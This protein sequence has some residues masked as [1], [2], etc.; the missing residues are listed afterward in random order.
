MAYIE[1]DNIQKGFADGSG[2]IRKVL[3]CL[4]LKVEQGDFVAVTGVS[5]TGKTTL[6]NILGTLLQPDGGTYQLGG[7]CINDMDERRLLQ[8]RN[9][10]IGFMFQ[11]YRLLP[12]LTAWLNILLPTL[13]IGKKPQAVDVAWAEELVQKMGIGNIVQQLPE[14]LSGGEKSRVALCRALIMRPQLLL[15]D[16]PTGQLDSH[17]ADEVAQLL[18]EVNRELGT[19]IVIVTHS[20]KLAQNAH[21]K[22][23]LK[24]GKL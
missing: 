10:Q 23:T 12:Q 3:D 1:L 24:E 8:L 4:N 7:E 11:D 20:E 19:T 2:G 9:R 17:H 6:L 5:G 21:Q 14:T 15:A 13:A 16:E 22:F 18:K